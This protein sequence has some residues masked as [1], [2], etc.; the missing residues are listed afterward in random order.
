MPILQNPQH[1]S[2]AQ[3][4]AKGAGLQ[5]AFEDAGYASDRSHACRLAKRDDVAARVAELRLAREK[6]EACEPQMII[7]ALVRMA[8]DG[9]GLKTAVGLKEARINLLEANRLRIELT[10]SRNIERT[11]I[12]MEREG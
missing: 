5:D 6:A 3:A 9:E 4:R 10:S 8:R 2:F 11:Q 1:E 7:D 12:A